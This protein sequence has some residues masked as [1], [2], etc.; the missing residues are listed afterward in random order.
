ISAKWSDV[1]V[2]AGTGV[3]LTATCVDMAGKSA[4]F[5]IRDNDGDR[6]VV[7]TLQASC[8]ESTVEAKWATPS[9]GPPSTF[10]FEVEA[11]GKTAVS[12]L[13]LIVKRVEAKL[14]LDGEP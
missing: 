13:L 2:Q 1:M 4:T 7:A 11:D 9:S 6:A 10:E 8:G 12:D 14:V 3:T 5:T